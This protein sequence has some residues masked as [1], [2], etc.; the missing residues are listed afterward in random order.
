MSDE[1]LELVEL[2][3]DMRDPFMDF[4]DDFAAAGEAYRED[5][6]QRVLD[7]FGG[8][9]RTIRN[10][11]RGRNLVPGYVSETMYVLVRGQTVLG[12]IHLRHGLTESLCDLGGH[13]GYAVRPSDRRKGY[14]TEMLRLVLDRA[15]RRGLRR[16]LVTCDSTN[17]ASARVIESNGGRLESESFSERAGRITRRYWIDLWGALLE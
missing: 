17:V 10:N 11:S 8:F 16:V 9:V 6:R 7:D 14:G 1:Q 2:T 3:E 4:L 15:R 5:F 12:G 13:I